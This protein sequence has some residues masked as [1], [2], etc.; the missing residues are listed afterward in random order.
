MSNIERDKQDERKEIAHFLRKHRLFRSAMNV[1]WR[2]ALYTYLISTERGRKLL[3]DPENRRF[4][5]DKEARTGLLEDSIINNTLYHPNDEGTSLMLSSAAAGRW[6]GYDFDRPLEFGPEVG[7]FFE[8]KLWAVPLEAIMNN[9]PDHYTPTHR[10]ELLD[11]A[12][13]LQFETP[14]IQEAIEYGLVEPTTYRK[15]FGRARQYERYKLAMS[16]NGITDIEIYRVTPKGN[17]L[18]F[19]SPDTGRKVKKP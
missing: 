9:A 14:S 12:H 4:F 11:A 10:L 16:L 19:L 13:L 6:V 15:A 2:T 17:G 8:G 3:R 18:I 7:Q 1:A 5:V